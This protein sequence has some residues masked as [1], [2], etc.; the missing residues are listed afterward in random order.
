MSCR[1]V[2]SRCIRQADESEQT[3]QQGS[4]IETSEA[5][6]AQVRPHIAMHSYHWWHSSEKSFPVYDCLFIWHALLAVSQI[7]KVSLPLTFAAVFDELSLQT[8]QS[9]VYC[10]ITQS[11]SPVSGHQ[12]QV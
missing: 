7:A 12:L 5:E 4:I 10:L 6:H 9:S 2:T 11:V 3:S 1:V 8:F